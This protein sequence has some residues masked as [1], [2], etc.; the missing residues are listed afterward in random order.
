MMTLDEVYDK[1]CWFVREY[2]GTPPGRDDPKSLVMMSD[3]AYAIGAEWDITFRRKASEESPAQQ[4][5]V[6]LD[7]AGKE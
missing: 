1:I 2:G 5:G 3:F 6:L 4:E 7:E